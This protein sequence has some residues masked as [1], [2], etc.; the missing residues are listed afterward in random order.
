MGAGTTVVLR[1]R[2]Y[3]VPP[4]PTLRFSVILAGQLDLEALDRHRADLLLKTDAS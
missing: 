1:I 3:G 4:T 2:A